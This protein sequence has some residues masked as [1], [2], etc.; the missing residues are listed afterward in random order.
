MSAGSDLR[1]KNQRVLRQLLTEMAVLA[2]S[3][4]LVGVRW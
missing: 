1:D 4:F 3:A 2:V